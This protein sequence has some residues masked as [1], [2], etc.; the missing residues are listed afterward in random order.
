M[1]ARLVADFIGITSYRMNPDDPNCFISTWYST[2]TGD[3]GLLGI[4]VAR[5]DTSNGFCGVFEVQYYEPNNQFASGVARPYELTITRKGQMRD[6]KW[7][8]DG[9]VVLEGIGIESGDQLVASYWRP[10]RVQT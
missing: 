2:R 5:G 9:Q 10:T 7:R 8:R 4:G 6:M 3:S 1:S